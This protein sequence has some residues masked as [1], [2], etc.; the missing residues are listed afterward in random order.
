MCVKSFNRTCHRENLV[1]FT[2]K[3]CAFPPPSLV[4]KLSLP[5]TLP[6]RETFH[7]PIHI[8]D[9]VQDPSF[10]DERNATTYMWIA[11][12]ILLLQVLPFKARTLFQTKW[13]GIWNEAE[14]EAVW[15]AWS[16]V[17]DIGAGHTLNKE[18]WL[19]ESCRWEGLKCKRT[20]TR[21]QKWISHPC[22][23]WSGCRETIFRHF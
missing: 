18:R 7:T 12:S 15:L 17:M 11:L 6:V 10:C 4:S 16:N 1:L 23:K 21:T 20:A 3:A 14:A 8:E 2:F 9:F 19:K 5:T 13:R 22:L